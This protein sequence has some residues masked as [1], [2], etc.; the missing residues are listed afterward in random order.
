[1]SHPL[2]DP[3]DRPVH[4]PVDRAADHAADRPV[5]VMRPYRPDDLGDLYRI[6]LLTSD[7]GQDATSLYR[8]PS[9]PGHVYAAPYG[10]FEPTFAFVVQ[11]AAGVGGYA[12]G[13]LESLAFERRLEG[14]WWPRL[15]DRYPEPPA[16]I[17]WEQQTAEQHIAYLIHHPQSTPLELATRYPSHLHI[18]LLPRL[19][20]HGRG[21]QLI[22]TLIEALRTRG[23]AGVHLHVGHGNERAASFYQRIGFTELSATDARVFGMRLA[24]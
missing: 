6:C 17:P 21:G 23:S 13:S 18:N 4:R 3:V 24:E 1:V 14:E 9:L 15:R 2:D 16:D 20:G 5:A 8:D 12:V 10:L 7:N 19:Q 11:D 22:K